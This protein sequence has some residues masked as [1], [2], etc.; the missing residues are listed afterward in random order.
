MFDGST[1]FAKQLV[2]LLRVRCKANNCRYPN[3]LLGV[4][5]T[6]ISKMSVE[7]TSLD[8]FLRSKVHNELV[9]VAHEYEFHKQII[10]QVTNSTHSCHGSTTQHECGH[11]C[12]C[13]F[14]EW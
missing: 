12:V 5:A 13:P 3:P 10:V 9:A 1:D 4:A 6:L 2:Q 7:E 8:T 11:V 14:V